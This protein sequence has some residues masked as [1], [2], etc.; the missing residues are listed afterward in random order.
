MP[1]IS[2]NNANLTGLSVPNPYVLINT[3]PP[4]ING[5]PS[6]ILGVVGVASWGPVGAAIT[7]GGPTDATGKVGSP[8]NRMHDLASAISF[9]NLSGAS[10]FRAVRVTDGTD[11]AA[12][13]TVMDGAAT[14]APQITFTGKYTGIFGNG[15]T[16]T[17]SAGSKASTFKVVIGAPGQV[18]ETFDNIAGTGLAVFTNMVSAI[19]NGQSGLRGPS[20]LVVATVGTSTLAPVTGT[21]TLA[22]GT[23]GVTTITGATLLGTDTAPRKGL[24]ALRGTGARVAYLADNSDSTTWAAEKAF[25]DSEGVDMVMVGPSGEYTN[26]ATAVSNRQ[27]AGI[28]GYNAVVLLGDWCYFNDPLTG[29]M[30]LASPQHAYAGLR[31]VLAPQNSALNKQVGGVIATQSSAAKYVYTDSD[32]SQLVEGGL[33]LITNPCPGGSYFGVRCGVNTSSNAADNS[34]NYSTLTNYIAYSMDTGIGG[35][36]GMLQTPSVQQE[37][38]A[39]LEH[40]LQNMV[41]AGQIEAYSVV[42]GSSNNPQSSVALGYMKALVRVTYFGVIR[43]FVVDFEGGATVVLPQA[44]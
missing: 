24:Y 7:I 37:A 35:Y 43:Y 16:A 26:I 34:D 8:V 29:A 2:G 36:I 25:G 14:P 44:A 1:V 23:D 31:S 19:N 40:F 38:K 11:T 42:L 15:I 41:D 32:I 13:Y 27:T 5:V 4:E 6:D 10:N 9:A 39:T 28:D 21:Y 20:N 33:E 18:P 22:G 3:P 17:I 30:R 12:T